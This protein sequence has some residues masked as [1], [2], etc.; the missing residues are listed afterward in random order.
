MSS[1]V[2]VLPFGLLVLVIVTVPV[3]ILDDRGLPRYRSMR[4][5]LTRVESN[6]QKLEREVLELSKHVKL[7][8]DDPRAIERIARDDLGMVKPGELIFQFPQ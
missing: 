1:N 7:L 4:A 5:Q 8:R 2:W 3:Y 6:N